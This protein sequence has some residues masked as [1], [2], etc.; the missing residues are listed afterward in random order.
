MSGNIRSIVFLL[1]IFTFSILVIYGVVDT[2]TFLII[3]IAI[4]LGFILTSFTL[5]LMTC[6]YNQPERHELQQQHEQIDCNQCQKEANLQRQ[7]EREK[8]EHFYA[9]IY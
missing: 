1:L 5:V 8:I 3:T 4:T 6:Y 2:K 9:S 7:E